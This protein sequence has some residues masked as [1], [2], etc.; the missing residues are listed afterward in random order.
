MCMRFEDVHSLIPELQISPDKEILNLYAR[1]SLVKTCA[2]LNFYIEVKE[3][4]QK[5]HWKKSFWI[6][7]SWI[8]KLIL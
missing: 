7:D 1:R 3:R 8:L 4:K 2:V 6:F 5:P